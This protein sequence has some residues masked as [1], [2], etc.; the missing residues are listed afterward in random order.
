[1]KIS[2]SLAAALVLTAS[3]SATPI[4]DLQGDSFWDFGVFASFRQAK[5]S[6]ANPSN[7]N[8]DGT[9]ASVF[10]FKDDAFC[11]DEVK[12]AN[13]KSLSPHLSSVEFKDILEDGK[14]C[15][16]ADKPGSLLSYTMEYVK[17]VEGMGE[18][19]KNHN[20]RTL[21]STNPNAQ[22]QLDGTEKLQH[23]RV[24][25]DHY[26]ASGPNIFNARLCGDRLYTNSSFYFN[27]KGG[28]GN[29]VIIGEQN[30]TSYAFA[31]GMRVC[32]VRLLT[33]YLL[34]FL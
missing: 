2:L 22:A 14:A 17:T 19:E 10:K 15:K 6:T 16:T 23:S 29:S 30:F 33:Y 24:S 3:G 31:R 34:F 27:V 7:W 1:M 32:F 28:Q 11:P 12:I 4:T 26:E 25:F 21:L 9:Y 8:I 13:S 5:Q 18:S 20:F